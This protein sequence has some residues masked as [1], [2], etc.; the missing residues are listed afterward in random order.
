VVTPLTALALLMVS[1]AT[2]FITAAFGIGG[3]VVLIG[4]LAT[5]LPPSALIPVHGL[6]QFGSN[7]GRLAI[8]R[9]HVVWTVFPAF[10]AGNILGAAT[11]GLIAVNLPAPAVQIGVGAFILFSVYAKIPNIGRGTG[12]IAGAFA[13][14][15]A[16][17]FGA[18]G[19]FV[20]AYVRSLGFGRLEH[21]ATHSAFMTAQHLIRVLVFGLLGFAFGPYLPLIIA[22]I[23]TGFVG[24]LI[25]RL[26]LLRIDDG[27]FRFALDAI[28]TLLALRLIWSGAVIVFETG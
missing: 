5:L 22:M 27:K 17:F 7:V 26:V 1:A 11:G 4:V 12:W 20:A 15:L 2:S 10:L 14:F 18:T 13:S 8:M 21:V 6:V 3:G 16:M 23:A 9:T 28:L 24:T 25:G 19:P